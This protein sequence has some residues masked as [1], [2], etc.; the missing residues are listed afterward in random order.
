VSESKG[1]SRTLDDIAPALGLR[2]GSVLAGAYLLQRVLGVGGG[3]IVVLATRLGD[4]R[5]VAVKLLRDVDD[6][7]SARRLLR[8]AAAARA[9]RGPHFVDV[10]DV[11]C[12]GS[13]VPFIVMEYLKGE[14][15]QERLERGPTPFRECVGHLLEASCGLAQ[16]HAQGI[17]HRDVKPSNLFLAA[18][19]DGRTCVKILDLGISRVGQAGV[20]D[21]QLTTASSVLGT[22]AY[23]SPEQ[24]TSPHDVDARAD[25]WSLG[26][27]LYTLVAGTRPFAGDTLPQ[28]CATIFNAT[29]VRLDQVCPDVPRELADVVERC[30]EKDREQRFA[31]IA[32]LAE[33]L[34]P[35][36][37]PEARGTFARVVKST[38]VALHPSRP[39]PLVPVRAADQTRPRSSRTSRR[40]R[41]AVAGGVAA[42]AAM[43][44]FAVRHA[45][46]PAPHDESRAPATQDPPAPEPPVPIAEVPATPTAAP[47]DPASHP[48]PPPRRSP[49]PRPVK[50]PARTKVSAT[51]TPPAVTSDPGRYR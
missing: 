25:V 28:L 33:A 19:Q 31:D 29:P 40:A 48:P 41:I 32:A 35:F 14:T 11:D 1:K 17:V 38:A 51:T 27:T 15:L 26:V 21:T 20:Y 49:A 3:G 7:M 5:E 18:G 22:P 43:L 9:I 2:E 50:V 39:S 8:E 12:V 34:D 16:A 30:L 6:E 13:N 24:L 23:S 37:P 44:V 46:A 10:L 45:K 36:A 47:A 42:L 4:G